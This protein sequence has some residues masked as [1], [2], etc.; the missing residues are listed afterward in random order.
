MRLTRNIR[1]RLLVLACLAGALTGCGGGSNTSATSSSPTA[2]PL[3]KA[4]YLARANAICRTMHSRID[5]I[6]NPG[7]NQFKMASATD[8]TAE[9]T[10]AALDQ[11]RALPAPSGDAAV[12][13]DIYGRIDKVLDDAAKF[14]AALRTQDQDAMQ[15]ANSRLAADADAANAASNA[16]G[17]TVCGSS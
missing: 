15:K 11:L 7:N 16:Y 10:A 17:E 14:S 9:I 3:T 13:K 4:E 8:Q 2:A 5:R 12:L 6:G 1:S